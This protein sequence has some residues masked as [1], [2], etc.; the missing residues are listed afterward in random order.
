MQS[1]MK[2]V[3]AAVL[4]GVFCT[5]VS[6]SSRV[7]EERRTAFF[8]EDV[9]IEVPSWS[10]P[11]VV[12]RPRTNSSYEVPLLQAG[13][14]TNPNKTELNALGHLV[15]K[16][17]QEEDEGLYIIR[18]SR[19]VSISKNLVLSVRDC[20]LEQVVKYGETYIIHLN[21]IEGP[22]TL[23]FRPS[24][25]RVNQTVVPHTSEPPPVLLY[26]Q[27]A[28]L[29]DDYAGRLSVSDRQVVLHSVRM[30]DEGSFTVLDRDGHTKTRTCLNV[31]D[32]QSFL[33]FAYGENLKMKLFLHYSNLNV[34]YRSKL[35]HQ[36]R[37]IVNQGVLVAPL[38][39]Q[40]EGRL[41]VD[42]SELVMKKMH[43]ADT[44]LFKVTDL[45][46]FT[47]AHV[48]ITV[49]AYKMAP[50][51]VAILSMLGL[52]AF[53]LLVCLLS[54]LYKIH[55]RNEKNKKLT[56]I[57]QQAGKKDGEAFRQVVHEAYSRFTEESL[58]TSVCDKPSE[59]TEVT[60]KG[61]EVSKPGRYQTLPS[62]NFLEMSDSGVEFSHSGLPLDSD[63]E[64]VMTYASHKPL[65]NAASPPAVTDAVMMSDSLE[66]TAALDGG[67]SAVRTPDSI[68]S[69]SPASNPRSASAA[70]PDGSLQ[71][72]ASPATASRGT[73][74]SD[75][76]KTEGG[77]EGE[78][79]GQ[80]E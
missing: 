35:D 16:D 22:I 41:T 62:D 34:V 12:F 8:G 71:G 15:L 68:L 39:P 2:A 42:G 79:D 10:D 77:A 48:Y 21:H 40:L 6:A 49:E 4:S 75:S 55:K 18:S 7:K 60:I 76:A 11:Q 56:L 58:M 9:H 59:T 80:K 57:A 53:M 44:G 24:L 52:I 32:H 65:L 70:T 46:G 78:E 37:V 63:T 29:G 14:V 66:A 23:E 19:N 20:A 61:L 3:V 51:A 38:D 74:G 67:L 5:V 33:H 27:S 13:R 31:R 64:A 69:A 72:A 25:V 43:P 1:K 47:V 36:D 28:V 54:C 17:V 26:N 45:A 73:A 50:L 30:T